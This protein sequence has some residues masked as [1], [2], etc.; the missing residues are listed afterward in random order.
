MNTFQER[1]K[2]LRIEHGY[3]QEEMGKKLN[4]TTSAYGY[5][6]Q[7]R[8]EPS[9]ETLQK[10]ARTF[11]VSTDYLLGIIDT[12]NHP[13]YHSISD[14]LSLSDTEIDT[15]KKMKDLSLL[16]EI[17]LNTNNINRLHRYW[18]FIKREHGIN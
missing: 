3:S 2:D 11:Q 6:E 5:Y 8:N 7:G 13:I 16:E 12:S 15:V 10:I 14:R 9:L 17:S 1:L 4:V 18:D